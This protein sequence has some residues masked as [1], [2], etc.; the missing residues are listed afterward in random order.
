MIILANIMEG[1]AFVLDS[2]LTF[3]VI[4]IFVRAIVSWFNPDPYN[5][6]MRFLVAATE[7]LLRPLRRFIPPLG[8]SIDVTPIVLFM[9]LYFLKIAFVQTIADYAHKMR[10]ESLRSAAITSLYH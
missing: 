6:G 3:L 5:P 7:P 8:G 1:L 4:L 9:L 10:I 2:I